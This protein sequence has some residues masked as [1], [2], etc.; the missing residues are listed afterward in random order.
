MG[1]KNAFLGRLLASSDKFSDEQ[2][3]QTINLLIEHAVTHNASDIH[4]EPHDRFVQVRYRIDNILKSVHKLPLAAL[5]AVV[6]Q[7]KE[8][9]RLN[10][11][12]DHLPQ[13]GQYATLVGED[14]F[15][16]QV[17]TMPVIGGEKVVLHLSRRLNK[18]PTLQQLGFWGD[19]LAILQQTLSA[20]HG[21]IIVATPR[22]NGKTTTL[23]SMLQAINTPAVS[24]ATVEDSI[25]FRLP[26][27]SQTIANTRHGVNTAEGLQ[28]ALNQD[29]NIVMLSNIPDRQTANAAVQAAVGGHLIIA[30]MHGDNAAKAIAQLQTMNDEDF[31][32]SG[33][34][35]AALSQRLVRRL[36]PHCAIFYTPDRDEL[37]GIEKAFGI[38]AQSA[39]QKVHELEQQ[40][41]RAGMGSR[42]AVTTPAGIT[43]LWR[44][45]EDGC[46][47]CNHSGYQGAV[48]VVEV[49]PTQD[50][51]VESTLI[52]TASA[53]KIRKVALKDGFVPM[54]LDGLIKSLR[55][56]TTLTELLRILSI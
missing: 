56:Q 9:A 3:S 18:P 29:P 16:I 43:H 15:E 12:Q 10:T 35:K 6:A 46:E 8:Q 19:A 1:V 55:G 4:I 11:G 7:I 48:A 51:D 33:A 34:V 13:E 31:L 50:N 41:I 2:V 23:H 22:R 40:A 54:E 27:A 37:H 30:G 24:I 20:T 25:E 52:S 39:R 47:E 49:L 45:S 53:E 21:L 32:F 42:Q 36:C 5:P 17:Y 14:Q 26:G 28:A 44:A 38:T